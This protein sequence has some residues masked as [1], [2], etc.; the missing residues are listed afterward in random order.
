MCLTPWASAAAAAAA[1]GLS[2]H[3]KVIHDTH[4]ALAEIVKRMNGYMACREW[5][6]AA[7]CVC[8]AARFAVLAGLAR[9]LAM[10]MTTKM[11]WGRMMMV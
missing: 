7:S 8:N 2:S 3:A 9:R 11:M 1:A 4:E 5:G 6:D 10:L